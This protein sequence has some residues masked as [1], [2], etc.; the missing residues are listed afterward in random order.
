MA[1]KFDCAREAQRDIARL[2]DDQRF[3]DLPDETQS[4]ITRRIELRKTE[5]NA[6]SSTPQ[7][8]PAAAGVRV[9]ADDRY[10]KLMRMTNIAQVAPGNARG[11]QYMLARHFNLG[12]VGAGILGEV[13]E[14]LSVKHLI[15]NLGK[16]GS[17]ETYDLLA[18]IQ[19]LSRNLNIEKQLR[20]VRRQ[21]NIPRDEWNRLKLDLIEVGLNP[22][23]QKDYGMVGAEAL[24]FLRGRQESVFNKM[25]SLGLPDEVQQNLARLTKNAAD[26]YQEVYEV[27]Q[28]F[29]VRAN[30]ADGLIRYFPRELSAQAVRGIHWERAKKGGFRIF[31]IN[32]NSSF[33]SISTIFSKSR[34]SYH[35]IVED[36]IVLDEALRMADPKLYET[37]GVNDI[38]DLLANTSKLTE[39]FVR[40]LDNR[41]GDLFDALVETGM[42]S[43]IPMTT[44]E[45]FDAAVQRYQLPFQHLNEFVATDLGEA[46]ELYRNSLE[47]SVGRS[48]MSNF[49]AKSAIEGGWGITEA[50]KLSNPALYGDFVQLTTPVATKLDVVIPANKAQQFGIP[51]FQNSHTYVHPTVAKLY[52]AEID[53]LSNPAHLGSFGRLIDANYKLFRQVLFNP[54]YAFRQLY[55][56]FFQTFAAG[57][58][59]DLYVSDFIRSVVN[60]ARLHK[61]G[62]TFDQF[63]S[64]LDSTRKIYRDGTELISEQELWSRARRRG[65]IDDILPWGSK[66]GGRATYTPRFNPQRSV[67]YLSNLAQ[68][69]ADNPQRLFE[70][71]SL[72]IEGV[73]DITSPINRQLG[74]FNNMADNI[75]RFSTLKSR[76][77]T[78]RTGVAARTLSGA[79]S[80]V[81]L[82]D[83]AQVV[84]EFFFDYSQSS[85]LD[86][87]A[88]YVIPF[89]RF[90]SRNPPAILKMM[91]RNPSRFMAYQRLWAMMNEPERE[92]II[93]GSLPDWA[94]GWTDMVWRDETSIFSMPR[95]SFDPIAEGTATLS[96]IAQYFGI[97]G[98]PYESLND[99]PWGEK[100]TSRAIRELVNQSFGF[101]KAA[102]AGLTGED[103]RTG[104]ELNDD[105]RIGSSLLGVDVSPL[106]KLIV[107]N[108]FPLV[109]AVD[110]SNPFSVFGTPTQYNEDGTVAAEATPSWAG[111]PGDQRSKASRFDTAW[112]R[113]I[114]LVGINVYRFN[115]F[116]QLGFKEDQILFTIKDG[117]ESYNMMRRNLALDWGQL[118]RAERDR[119]TATMYLY[120][121]TIIR[122]AIDHNQLT[123]WGAERGMDFS[124]VVRHSRRNNR[125][126]STYTGMTTDELDEVITNFEGLMP[127][128]NLRGEF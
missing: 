97:D 112:Q 69:F 43:K 54:A 87:I 13:T 75:G 5:I 89:W 53:L 73:N 15:H 83:A 96:G 70:L 82:D 21:F 9:L 65:L 98:S 91:I 11:L 46:A 49:V 61:Q 86:N 17:G 22:Y 120:R 107:E 122:L 124:A 85:T 8:T 68:S 109:S 20:R 7:R 26:T 3:K 18:G 37:L 116:D 126:V 77:D 16:Y 88:Q 81:G 127:L 72:V 94:S 39:A 90:R 104:R 99:V 121:D 95:A 50:E 102:Y 42:I 80:S 110:R 92:N 52:R 25:K 115:E 6:L 125:A 19:F 111:T 40:H 55:S 14:A 108:M 2:F 103:P 45:V 74:L 38:D 27:I 30:D 66:A 58:R 113:T 10:E 44:T 117:I 1:K 63:G 51:V 118:S 56:P 67:A 32:G 33:D 76:L 60:T 24:E 84:T 34:T 128:P 119:R 93:E 59:P 105:G 28:A 100:E 78:S 48:V 101:I 62:K 35:Y 79:S 114:S 31:D 106:S 47:R 4:D 64:L 123:N 41:A 12:R 23:T 29:G 57:G 71:P 36:A